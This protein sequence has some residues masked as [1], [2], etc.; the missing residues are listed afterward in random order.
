[1][2]IVARIVWEDDGEDRLETVALG[3]TRRNVYVRMTDTRDR[4]RAV[5]PAAADVTVDDRIEVL[6]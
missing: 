6:C 3:W 4:L 2:P 5:W 1:V